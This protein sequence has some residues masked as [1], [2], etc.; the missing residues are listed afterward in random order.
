MIDESLYDRVGGEAIIG[1]AVDLFYRRVRDDPILTR[2]FTSVDIGRLRAHQRAFLTAALGGADV[3][4]GRTLEDAHRHLVIGDTAFDAL[5]DHM[6]G[7]LRDLG[8]DESAAA[9]VAEKLDTLRS[10]VIS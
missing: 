8:V 7:A 2:Y 5:V 9:Q 6:V 4:V 3:F 10:R 1:P